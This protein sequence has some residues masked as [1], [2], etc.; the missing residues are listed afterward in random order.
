MAK[1]GDV[2]ASI[3]NKILMHFPARLRAGIPDVER[4]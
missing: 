2:G 4:I 1:R 3:S